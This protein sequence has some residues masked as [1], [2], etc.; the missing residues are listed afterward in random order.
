MTYEKKVNKFNFGTL[1]RINANED[2][3]EENSIFG[4][5]FNMSFLIR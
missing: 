4:K 1:L 2:Y 5:E 3:T